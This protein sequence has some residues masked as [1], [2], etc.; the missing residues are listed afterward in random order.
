MKKTLAVL[1]ALVMALGIA[2]GALAEAEKPLVG[3]LAPFSTHAW[4]AA[5]SYNAEYEAKELGLNYNM[6]TSNTIAEM[7]TQMDDMVAQGAKVIV[8][9]PQQEGLEA[10]AQMAIDAGVKIVKFDRKINVDGVHFLAGD[11]YD[12]GVQSAKY[13]A[14]KLGGAGK[15]V[16][17]DVPTSGSVAAERKQG[18]LDTI[19]AEAPGIEII[20][21][22]ATQ[23]N[24]T[25]GLKDMADVLTAYPQIDGVFSMDDETSIGALQAISEAGRTDIKVITG[26]GG[27]QE[28]FNMM[29]GSDIHI[30]SATYSP[31]MMRECVKLAEKLLNGEEVAP[32]TTIGTTIVDKSNVENFLD[33]NSPY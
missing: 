25:D 21:T 8:V 29:P 33:P 1:L 15:V 13:I 32:S 17:L 16:I 30:A 28:Y 10:A 20:A 3:I 31:A 9:N 4:V 12:M 6:Q 2:G 24:R 22:I 26:G 27:C 19:A 7:A 5:V 11:N 14:E 18:F 23:F